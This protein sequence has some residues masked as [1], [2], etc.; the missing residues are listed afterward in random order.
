[1]HEIGR[2]V[3]QA[4]VLAFRPAEFDRQVLVLYKARF[5]QALAQCSHQMRK[6]VRRANVEETN[7]AR[8][9]LLRTR[10]QRPRCRRAAK[11]RDEL[12]PRHSMTSSA[13]AS[14]EGG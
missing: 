5:L 1:M 12:A 11:Q 10:C 14:S 2:Q 3:R 9:G 4:V 6:R 7:N 8:P 13:V